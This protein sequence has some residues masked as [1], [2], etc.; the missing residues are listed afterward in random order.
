M[1][2]NTEGAQ[3]LQNKELEIKAKD[4]AKATREKGMGML[5]GKFPERL[6]G[7]QTGKNEFT[8]IGGF[9]Q[10]E[11][12]L[13]GLMFPDTPS[14]LMQLFGYAHRQIWSIN[15]YIPRMEET[16]IDK[17][18][19]IKGK[20]FGILPKTDRIVRKVWVQTNNPKTFHGKKG[21]SD[22]VQFTYYIPTVHK[23]DGRPGIFVQ[24]SVVVPPNIASQI[25]QEVEKNVYFPDAFFNALYPGYLGPDIATNIKMVKPTEL[26]IADRRKGKYKNEVRPYP[27]PLS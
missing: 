21:E 13:S 20:K 14:E 26:Q 18:E 2:A 19:E 24:M 17:I 15:D 25:E 12:A 10:G 3:T 5:H 22:W 7:L 9:I 8:S 23:Y 1:E 16:E 27:Q 4:L 6:L 11:D